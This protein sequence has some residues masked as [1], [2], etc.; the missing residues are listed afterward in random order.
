MKARIAFRPLSANH[1]FM[2]LAL[3]LLAPTSLRAADGPKLTDVLK[4]KPVQEGIEYQTPTADEYP[5]CKVDVEKNG[6]ASGW[7]VLGPQGEVLRRFTDT[8]G[9]NIVDQWKY[10]QY[11]IEVYRDVD[12]NFDN[13]VDQCRWLN[14]AGSRWGI[15]KNADGKI[16]EWKV[17]SAQEASRVAIEAFINND[18]AALQQVMMTPQEIKQL[19]ISN[20]LARQI[21]ENLND[22]S[23]QLKK[24]LSAARGLNSQSRWM[25]F[26]ATQPCL[27]PADEGKANQDLLVYENA[28]SIV[29]AGSETMLVQVGEIVRIGDV[30]KLTS[31]P[32]ALI[33]DSIQLSS[34][35]LMQPSITSLGNT[36]AMAGI[37]EEVQKLLDALQKLDSNSPSPSDNITEIARYN[38]NRADL[39]EKLVEAS[40]NVEEKNQWLQQMID[41]LAAA[42][43]T[44]GYPKG[45]DRLIKLEGSLKGHQLSAYVSYRRILAE[46]SARLKAATADEDRQQVQSWW[47]E[48]LEKFSTENTESIDAAEAMFQLALAQEFSG[49]AREAQKWYEKIAKTHS[50]L[51]VAKRATGALKRLNSEEQ[52][53]RLDGESLTGGKVSSTQYK[54]KVLLVVY[55]ATWSNRCQEDLPL[56]KELYE[57]YRA[58]GF[59]IL[60]VNID[61]TPEN[62]RPYLTKEKIS[63]Q[64]IYEP[65]GDE[66]PAA[67]EYG[68]IMVPTMFLVDK[69]GTVHSRP[70]N[71]EDLQKLL[72]ELLEK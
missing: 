31:V 23:G 62:V 17:L 13:K 6:K 2:L 16:D 46:Y 59:E 45:L 60:G 49:E 42:V 66:S 67:M 4:F 22:V 24:A 61:Q 29:E 57:K 51:S 58:S 54:G 65:G 15:D 40:S 21:Q 63:W 7:V 69:Q 14:T 72:P 43:Q 20:E 47:L 18:A 25:R 5:N 26:D 12:S 64:Q 38:A 32:Q 44:G 9:D 8:N 71:V 10:Y 3:S 52:P 34:G 35:I 56:L 27:I 28:M 41:G 19:G 1:F 68:I 30:W 39:L 11:G 53:F 55:W 37:P 36:E 70:S 33:G 48:E 50:E